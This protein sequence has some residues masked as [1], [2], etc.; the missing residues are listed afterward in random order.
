[1]SEK[2]GALLGRTLNGTLDLCSA[3]NEESQKVSE[4]KKGMMTMVLNTTWGGRDR[5]IWRK[6]RWGPV[7][8]LLQ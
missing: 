3:D 8:R 2:A 6:E 4:L 7:R 5:W 1:M